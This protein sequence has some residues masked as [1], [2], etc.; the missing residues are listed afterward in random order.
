MPCR[1][2]VP[3]LMAAA[4]SPL[5]AIDVGPGISIQGY[6]DTWLTV[7]DSDASDDTVIDFTGEAFAGISWQFE[8][9]MTTDFWAYYANGTANLDTATFT[10]EVNDTVSIFGGH[11]VNVLGWEAAKAP[12]RYRFDRTIL[13]GEN[14]YGAAY[15]EGVGFFFSPT[16]ESSLK[17]FVQ[18][19]VF[20]EGIITGDNPDTPE[21]EKDFVVF[22]LMP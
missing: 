9:K 12:Y 18:D 3:A 16:E 13:I 1:Y 6:V 10:W 19:H 20:G 15:N 5:S 2:I 4:V 17:V 22:E 11:Y 8:E 14:F 21:E 7:Q